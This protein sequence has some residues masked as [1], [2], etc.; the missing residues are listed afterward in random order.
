MVILFFGDIFG[1]TGRKAIASELPKLKKQYA[2]DFIIGNVENLAGGRGVNIKTLNEMTSLGFHGFTSGNH[3]WDNKEV[4]QIF[5]FETRL[6]RPAN[7]PSPKGEPCPGSGRG[8]F[9]SGNKKLM[10]INLIGRVFMDSVDCPFQAADQILS[11]APADMPIL[12]D[13]H[14]DATSEKNAMGWFLNGKV[15]AVV[16]T[17]SHVQTADE[18]VLPG[19]TAYIT[20]IGM[21]GSFDS[22]IGL[23]REG[24]LKRFR[25]KRHVTLKNAEENPGV[26]AVVITIGDNNKAQSIKRIRYALGDAK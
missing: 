24:I 9:V 1:K 19:G 25:V 26:S 4:L 20:D 7:Y 17:H 10:V 5:E 16:G 21:T 18:R 22:V 12:V 15:S 11:E 13:M 23:E 6:L 14:C 8:V 3:I 2:P